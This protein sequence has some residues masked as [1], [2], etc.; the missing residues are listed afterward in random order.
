MTKEKSVKLHAIETEI[1]PATAASKIAPITVGNPACGC[2]SGDRSSTPG[3]TRQFGR[4][5]PL[6]SNVSGRRGASSS[7]CGRSSKSRGR[8]VAFTSCCNWKGAT[9][10][11]SLR[12]S[13]SKKKDEEDTIRPVMLVRY[14]TMAGEE[15][16]WPL[17]LNP[18]DGKSNAWNTSALN[19]LALAE[20]GWVRIVSMKKHYRHQISN[21]T[22]VET[23][24]QFTDRSFDELVNAAFKEDQIVTSLDHEIWDVLANGSKK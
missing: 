22:L 7:P 10:T 14:V 4:T 8:T 18:P 9:R 24:P 17:K 23:P 13:R 16:L 3:R 20:K 21:K 6:S 2:Q 19:I 11:S 5:S 1:D 15:G 12:Q